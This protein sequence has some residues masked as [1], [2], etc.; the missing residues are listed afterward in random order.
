MTLTPLSQRTMQV[1]VWSAGVVVFELLTGRAP[2]TAS[3]APKII[4]VG[5][6]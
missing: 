6:R 3:S 5:R 4:E 1:D 2:F